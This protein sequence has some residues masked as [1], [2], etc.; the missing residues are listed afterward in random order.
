MQT[1]TIHDIRIIPLSVTWAGPAVCLSQDVVPSDIALNHYKLS[2]YQ[3]DTK[4][5]CRISIVNGDTPAGILIYRPGTNRHRRTIITHIAV[6]PALQRCGIASFMLDEMAALIPDDSTQA[7]LIHESLLP[8][9]CLFR[10]RGFRAEA[11]ERGAFMD[12]EQDGYYF[13]LRR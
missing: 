1:T 6:N 5:V 13:V 3:R 4:T 8:A 7:A 2:T 12:G 10:K 9:H 11:I